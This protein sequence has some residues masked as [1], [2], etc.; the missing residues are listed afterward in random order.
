MCQR[1]LSKRT[2]CKCCYTTGDCYPET[3]FAKAS[4]WSIAY[5]NLR[6]KTHSEW[7]S[8]IAIAVEKPFGGCR[9]SMGD[10]TQL[11]CCVKSVRNSLHLTDDILSNIV[12]HPA[13][14]CIDFTRI[15]RIRHG[16]AFFHGVGPSALDCNHLIDFLP[17]TMLDP[18]H[19]GKLNM[20]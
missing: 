9:D 15:T 18:N 4:R 10:V 1:F 20:F 11:H 6:P 13:T 16:C 3:S 12:K 2:L 14:P 8:A 19:T 7:S 17:L 5:M